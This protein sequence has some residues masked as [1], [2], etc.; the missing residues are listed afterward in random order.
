LL[1][2]PP[3]Q[4][5]QWWSCYCIQKMCCFL[6]FSISASTLLGALPVQQNNKKLHWINCNQAEQSIVVLYKFC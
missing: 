5:K 4:C 1:L 3:M 2:A 6:S